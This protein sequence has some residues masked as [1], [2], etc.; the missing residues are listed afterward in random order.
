MLV[1]EHVLASFPI[2]LATFGPDTSM[3]LEVSTLS[4]RN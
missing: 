1:F 4:A 2:T 3:C